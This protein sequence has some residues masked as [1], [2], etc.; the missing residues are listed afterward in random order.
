MAKSEKPKKEK[1]KKEKKQKV[2]PQ[3]E[4]VPQMP[5]GGPMMMGPMGPMGP[6]APMQQQIVIKQKG[7]GFITFLTVLLVLIGIFDLG[8]GFYVWVNRDRIDQ[9]TLDLFS[10]RSASSQNQE[11]YVNTGIED[12]DRIINR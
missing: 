11:N 6:M 7:R 10:T 4:P 8:M 12:L 1:V 3:A 9:N 5:P 2:E